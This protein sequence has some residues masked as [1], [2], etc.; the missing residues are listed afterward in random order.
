MVMGAELEW[1]KG[2]GLEWVEG[3][4]V[5]GV[6]LVLDGVCRWWMRGHSLCS[7]GQAEYLWMRGG[8]CGGNACS[9]LLCAPN[10]LS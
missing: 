2:S 3:M 1:M 5:R 8:T 9:L 4:A 10:H 7:L 6:S